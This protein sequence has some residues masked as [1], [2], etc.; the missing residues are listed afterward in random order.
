MLNKKG[1]SGVMA[2]QASLEHQEMSYPD[3]DNALRGLGFTLGGNWDYTSGCFDC[4]LNEEQTSWLRLPFRVVSG[5]LDAEQKARDTFIRFGTPYVTALLTTAVVALLAGLVPIGA[6]EEM[7]NIGTL[8]AFVVVS[9]GVV[10]LRRTRPDLPRAFRVPWVPVLPLLAAL[11]CLWLML[12]LTGLTW[13]RF[14]I[15]M[16]IGVVVYLGYGRRHSLLGRSA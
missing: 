15:W 6:L 8:F 1:V 12:N 5:T 14:G 7:V 2:R 11:A 3:A 10:V 16:L 4:A 13:I 9:V